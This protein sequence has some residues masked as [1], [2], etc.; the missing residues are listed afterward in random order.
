M[1]RSLAIVLAVIVA[2][3][4]SPLAQTASDL[5]RVYKTRYA[6][7]METLLCEVVRFQTVAGNAAAHEEQKRWLKQQAEKLGLAFRD[8]G[9][10][11]EVE[12]A[13]PAD[14]PVL[15]LLV[16]G[17]VQPPGDHGWTFPPFECVS[18][19]GH[20]YGRGTA[21]DKGPLVQA[22]LAMATLRENPRPRTHTVRLLVGSDEESNNTDISTYLKTHRAPHLTL[23]LDSDF[24]VVVG[25]KAWDALEL[26]VSDPYRPRA[27]TSAQWAIVHLDAGVTPSIVPPRAVARLRGTGEPSAAGAAARTLCPADVPADYRCEIATE[28][29][30]VIVTVTG[31]AAH[32]GMNLEG[33][34]NALVFLARALEGKVHPSGAADLLEFAALAGRDLHGAGLGITQEDPLWG[35]YNVNV[36]MLKG[37]DDGKLKLTI[38]LRRI[39]PMTGA[40]LKAHLA[41]QVEAFSARKGVRIEVGGFFED[42]PF[43][44]PPDAR[45]VKRLLAAYERATGAPATPSIAGGG[46]YARRLPNAIAFGMWF[47]GSPYPGHDVNEK[48]RVADLHRGVDV[49]LEALNDLAYSPP[50]AEPLRP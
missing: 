36:A 35:K 11:A 18:R 8:A 28:G 43:S 9:P 29:Q 16:H 21:D 15:G 42:S 48:I 33:G 20:V 26:S 45:L 27:T 23:V 10:V 41:T 50:L 2:A 12:L 32:S 3:A 25:E 39:P 5:R 6:N 17:D 24:P 46:T 30:D 47:P 1:P 4:A 7:R 19:D 22:L 14:A 38:N 31:R 40:Q 49:L 34:R 13:G 44:V 37:T